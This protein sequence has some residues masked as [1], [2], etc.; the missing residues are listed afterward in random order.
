MKADEV[1]TALASRSVRI[2]LTRASTLPPPT[3]LRCTVSPRP[4]PSVVAMNWVST[5]ALGPASELANVASDGAANPAFP[6]SGYSAGLSSTYNDAALVLPPSRRSAVRST[7]SATNCRISPCCCRRVNVCRSAG[8][9]GMAVD[10]SETSPPFAARTLLMSDALIMSPASRSATT[11]IT[12]TAIQ[13]M[14]STV[15]CPPL[16]SDRVA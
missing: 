10:T 3:R 16:R 4:A 1:P 13:K 7:P 12:P 5:T 11:A 6:A 14:P 15:R 2:A 8:A 9:S